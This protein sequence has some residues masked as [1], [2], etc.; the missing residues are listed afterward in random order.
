MSPAVS[1]HHHLASLFAGG[2]WQGADAWTGAG[3]STLPAVTLKSRWL[4]GGEAGEPAAVK[5]CA[6]AP[7]AR[8]A[9]HSVSAASVSD[10]AQP[11]ALCLGRQAQVPPTGGSTRVASLCAAAVSHVGSVV[12]EESGT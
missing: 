7:D 5:A 8:E 6:R 3:S 12:S 4:A 11:W 10:R 2:S 1:S 9:E